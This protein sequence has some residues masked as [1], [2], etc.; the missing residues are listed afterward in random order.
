MAF[1]SAVGDWLILAVWQLGV[2]LE[3]RSGI[4]LHI[5]FGRARSRK[6]QNVML[7]RV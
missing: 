7:Q 4:H 3:D 6:I 5:Q 1:S 2:Q